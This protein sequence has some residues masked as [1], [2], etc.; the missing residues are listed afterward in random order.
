MSQSWLVYILLYCDE[1]FKDEVNL[2]ILNVT[3]CF[4]LPTN[5][6]DEPHYLL[7]IFSCFSFFSWLHG[8][9]FT[10]LNILIFP[11]SYYYFV[12]LASIIVM[13][14]GCCCCYAYC[15]NVHFHRKKR[16]KDFG[17]WNFHKSVSKT[18][19]KFV[20]SYFSIQNLS[21][22][23]RKRLSLSLPYATSAVYGTNSVHFKGML[24]W[25]KL[26]NFIKSNASVF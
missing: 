3:A 19:P 24:I 11:F 6:F 26:P 14:P 10:V 12:S 5:I 4:V 15:A 22:N 16:I 13:V 7:W 2:L 25:N 17:N 8:C 21:Y 9:N 18:N 23:R 1:S 20:W